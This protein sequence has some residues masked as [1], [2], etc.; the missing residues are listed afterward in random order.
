M[1]MSFS[2]WLAPCLIGLVLVFLSSRAFS[3]VSISIDVA[4]PPLIVEDQPPVPD[5]GYI[6]T[7]GFWAY[8]QDQGAYYWVS[9]AWV[10]PPE[11]GL[12]WTPDYWAWD[13]NDYVYNPGYWGP[14]VGFYGGVNYGYGYWGNGYGGGHWDSGHFAYNTAA[15]NV[16]GGR[17]HNTYAD[18]SAVRPQSNRVSFNGGKGGIQ[19]Q[20]TSQE[21]QAAQSNHV[22]PTAQQQAR[23]QT[24]AQ[25]RSHQVKVNAKKP[26]TANATQPAGSPQSSGQN[27]QKQPEDAS[28][29][30]TPVQHE[31]PVSPD[32]QSKPEGKPNVMNV[33]QPAHPQIKPEEKPAQGSEHLPPP[34]ESHPAQGPGAEVKHVQP[35]GAPQ[36]HPQG[37]A[38]SQGNPQPKDNG[39]H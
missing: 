6:W 4:P 13:G 8:D 24:A 11:V 3:Q 15:N 10:Q 22:Q 28:A 29:T 36:S 7:P 25:T 38:K 14:T 5:D 23:F 2:R 26:A 31:P 30:I 17:V 35:A 39:Q 37:D 9:G 33:E 21:Q 20:P 18:N 27:A 16:S 19:A 32:H 12:Y 1:N 34:A